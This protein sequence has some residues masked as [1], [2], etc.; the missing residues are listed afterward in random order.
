MEYRA[1]GRR[2]SWMMPLGAHDIVD[3]FCSLPWEL[4]LDQAM[5]K[6]ATQ[7]LFTGRAAGLADIGRVGGRFEYDDRRFRQYRTI[8][9]LQPLAGAVLTRVLPAAKRYGR[10]Q[11]RTA[12]LRYGPT[13]LRH[14]FLTDSRARATLL[15]RIDAIDVDLLKADGVRAAVLD[16][17]SS[18]WAFQ[19]LLAGALTV[20][21]VADEARAVWD[22]ARRSPAA[23]GAVS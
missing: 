7:R 6:H 23:A 17:R 21:G 3:V 8:S 22:A 10:R 20:Q 16:A 11:R 15:D 9:R 1:Y 4:R 2:A 13:P 14:W 18:E 12:P 5:Y 19:L